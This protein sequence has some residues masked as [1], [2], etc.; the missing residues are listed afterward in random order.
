MEL[1]VGCRRSAIQRMKTRVVPSEGA[2]GRMIRE[3]G[4]SYLER[5]LGEAPRGHIAVSKLYEPKDS[6]TKS[7][8]WWFDLP[9]EAI[10]KA[11]CTEVHLLCQ[12]GR[13][14]FYYLRVPVSFILD[15]LGSLDIVKKDRLYLHL[16]AEDGDL[17]CDRRGTGKIDFSRWLVSSN[18]LRR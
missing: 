17:F 1:V 18:E 16:S 3:V 2:N 12:R 14:D 5:C 7:F 9:L 6:S 4:L 15:R 11:D 13:E 10:K 8:V